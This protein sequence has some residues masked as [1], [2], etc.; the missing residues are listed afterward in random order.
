[1]KLGLLADI[2]EDVERLSEAIERLRSL[3]AER[4]VMLG[5]VF[6]A[7][8]RDRIDRVAG[9]LLELKAEG[10]WG[11]HD[12]GLCVDPDEYVQRTFTERT[13]RY[14]TSLHDRLV[15]DGAHFSH[16]EPWLD[17]N[18]LEDLWQCGPHPDTPEQVAQSFAAVPHRRIFMG[19]NHRWIA[20]VPGK[21]LD[22]EGESTL[23]FDP[24]VRSFVVVHAVVDGWCA[25]FD[26]SEDVLMPVKLS[27]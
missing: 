25:L 11:N 17:P 27:F 7:G 10:V 22:W 26:T 24:N 19:H 23:Q 12:F 1:M 16:I 13:L 8:D 3:G 18:A 15:V 5:D 20:A 4:F 6:D 21:L 9:L 2:H 14:M